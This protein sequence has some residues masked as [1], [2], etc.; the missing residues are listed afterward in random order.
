MHVQAALITLLNMLLLA[1]ATGLVG[2]ARGKHGLHA[3]APT[4]NVAFERVFRAHQNTIESTVMFLPTLWLA[5]AWCNE[6]YAAWLG[7]AGL[8][9]RT[10]Y[11]LAYASPTGKRGYGFNIAAFANVALLLWALAC[12]AGHLLGRA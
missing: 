4:G 2:R 7:D 6:T 8:V 5:S 12:V 3:P 10:W 11:L 9:G 1:L